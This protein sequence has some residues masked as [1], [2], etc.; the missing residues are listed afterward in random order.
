MIN[1]SKPGK[2]PELVDIGIVMDEIVNELENDPISIG[3]FNAQGEEKYLL[4]VITGP[5]FVQ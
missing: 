3:L 1:S 4:V 2:P 5:S